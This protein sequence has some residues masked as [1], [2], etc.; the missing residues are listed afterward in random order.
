[1]AFPFSLTVAKASLANY[2]V[3][4]KLAGGPRH[5]AFYR[6]DHAS[7][8]LDATHAIVRAFARDATARGQ[9]PIVTLMPVCE[10]LEYLRSH[11]VLPHEPLG[12]LIAADTI[13]SIDFGQE[14]AKRLA[15][16]APES[17][18][19]TCSGHF[20]AAGNRLLAEIAADFLDSDPDIRRSLAAGR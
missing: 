5:A 1:M 6:P 19:V 15:G 12:K 2:H 13:R 7:R 14:I 11:G 20:N 3:R 8:A 17:L 16:A 9:I 10:D 18:Y 4:A